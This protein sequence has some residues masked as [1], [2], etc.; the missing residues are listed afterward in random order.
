MRKFTQ[1]DYEAVKA[2]ERDFTRAIESRYCTGLLQNELEVVQKIYNECLNRQ[3]NLSCGGCV[4]QMMTSV[5]RLYFGYLRDNPVKEE[6]I[7]PVI[8]EVIP[9]DVTK[10]IEE[11]TEVITE[12]TDT[13]EDTTEKVTK[14]N[15][16]IENIP[17]EI[18]TELIQDDKTEG[19]DN[20][21]N[22]KTEGNDNPEEP[23][24]VLFQDEKPKKERKPRKSKTNED[25]TE[26]KTGEGMPDA[27]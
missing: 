4:L 13:I 24:D 9:E 12:L 2:Y 14:L 23:V 19:N 6:E 1:A 27:L 15:E 16:T 26:H 5:G 3:A 10:P 18:V 8:E 22:D 11:V 20:P 7:T 17:Q 21:E 25:K